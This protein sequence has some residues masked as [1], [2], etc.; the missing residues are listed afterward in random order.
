MRVIIRKAALYD[1]GQLI[2]HIKT[3]A[4]ELNNP[5]PLAPPEYN[6]SVE[7]EEKIIEEFSE[8]DN[9]ILLVAEINDKVIG[10]LECSGGKS[11]INNHSVNLIISIEQGWRN[12]GVGKLLMQ[13]ALVWARSNGKI[14]RIQ[15]SVYSEN[16][17][18]IRLYE[19]F[20][21]ETE[22]KR[23]MVGQHQGKFIDDISMVLFI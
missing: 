16:K 18:A 2:N 11:I 10:Y 1:A 3:L 6:L 5:F 14:R 21:F 4:E 20:G 15:L 8:S 19:A 9:S 13:A 17:A 23:K 12:Q 22:G 7:E